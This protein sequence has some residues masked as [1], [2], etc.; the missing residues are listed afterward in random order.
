MLLT[1]SSKEGWYFFKCLFVCR[2]IDIGWGKRTNAWELRAVGECSAYLCVTLVGLVFVLKWTVYQNVQ[3]KTGKKY[4][5]GLWVAGVGMSGSV[6]FGPEKLH[7]A[8]AY[9]SSWCCRQVGG[10][11]WK[12][13]HLGYDHTVAKHGCHLNLRFTHSSVTK[14]EQHKMLE[15]KK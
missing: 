14:E 1:P 5:L 15:M 10:S 13:M 7:I 8:R 3:Y 2:K 12:N 9:T 11:W 4:Y 6:Y